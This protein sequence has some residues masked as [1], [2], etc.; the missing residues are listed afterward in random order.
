MEF[1]DTRSRGKN[2]GRKTRII[3][4]RCFSWCFAEFELSTDAANEVSV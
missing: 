2:F 3:A 4:E 1:L